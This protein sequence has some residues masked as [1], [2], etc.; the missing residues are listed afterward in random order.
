[1]KKLLANKRGEGYINTAVIIIIAVV[2]GGLLLGGLYLL[3]A[4]DSGVMATLDEEVKSMLHY[5]EPAASF[6]FDGESKM[7]NLQYSYDGDE[8]IQANVPEE[9]ATASVINILQQD[10]MVVAV[11]Y[12]TETLSCIVSSTDGGITWQVCQRNICG[13]PTSATID[14]EENAEQFRVI[15]YVNSSPNEFISSDAVTWRD[16]RAPVIWM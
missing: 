13:A 6:Q 4:G 1:M 3:F 7:S 9:I 15:I 2:I 14:W 11:V 8:W 10:N 12:S 5:N 16:L